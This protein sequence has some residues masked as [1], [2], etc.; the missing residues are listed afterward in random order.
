MKLILVTLFC[1]MS[2]WS[3]ALLAQTEFRQSG[4]HVHGVAKLT[5]LQD[6]NTL[7]IELESPAVNI[8]G[9]EHAPQD[10]A[11]VSR[12]ENALTLLK[13]SDSIVGLSSLDC[14]VV[15]ARSDIS[16]AAGSHGHS[17]HHHDHAHDHNHDHQHNHG[18]SEFRANIELYCA[19]QIPPAELLITAF[20]HFNGIETLE[21]QWALNGLQGMQRLNPSQTRVRFRQ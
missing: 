11:Q 4:A 17:A 19:S 10:D 6:R 21:I 16:G 12:I 8:V 15:Q 5:V 7:L 18:H 20:D 9:F 14:E 1:A 13:Q 3:V 2:L